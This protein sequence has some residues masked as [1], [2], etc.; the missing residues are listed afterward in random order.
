MI[1][2]LLS[3]FGPSE[4]EIKAQQLAQKQEKIQA[5]IKKAKRKKLAEEKKAKQQE[6]KIQTMSPKDRATARG[7]PW[8]DVINFNVNTDN[9]KHGYYE[10]DWNDQ[11]ISMLKS[12]GYGLAGDP[13]EEIVS[14]WFRDICY[15]VAAEQEID[16]S[17]RSTG[18]INVSKI[19]TNK[20][21][22]K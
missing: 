19:T 6:E 8:V 10:L 11:F 13:E 17:Q 9:I 20:S 22:V 15:S 2:K 3:I 4:S 1:K 21:E 5:D 7:E 16:M 18:Y 12:E 14:R